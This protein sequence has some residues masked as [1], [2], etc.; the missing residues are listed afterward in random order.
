MS[1]AGCS[2]LTGV[3]H[4]ACWWMQTRGGTVA[5][6]AVVA[7]VVGSDGDGVCS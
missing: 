1:G 7:E 6:V 2:V 5:I 3:G 4:G